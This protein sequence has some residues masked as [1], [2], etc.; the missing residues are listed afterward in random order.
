MATSTEYFYNLTPDRIHQAFAQAGLELTPT[1]RWLNSMENRVVG[2]EDLE[3]ERW[4]GKFY[5]PGRWSRAALEE[6]HDFMDEL[7]E[8]DLPVRP[9]VELENGATVG[10]VEGIFFTIFPHHLG[11]MPDEV[12]FEHA[13]LLGGLV[14]R[15]HQVGARGRHRRRPSVGPADWGLKSLQELAREKVV[16]GPIWQRYQERVQTL[17]SRLKDRFN[18]H[19]QLR[20]HGDLHRGNILWSS[21]GPSFVDFDDTTTGP[22]VQDLWMLLPGRDNDALA[23]RE[24][25]LDSYQRHRAFDRKELEL[26][27]P[28]RAL[29]FVRHAAWVAKR[30]KD[31]AFFRLYPDVESH[32]FWRRELDD[33]E[34]QLELVR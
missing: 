31:P 8:A 12:D 11:R 28:L 9:P 21:L 13:D 26:I 18:R 29:K 17:C 15:L 3:G 27:E 5:R 10:Q 33:L 20:L 16:P 2:V 32:G 24:V 1:L 19:Q 4:V 22:A 7:F 34:G 25:F 23:L 30:R 14:A 6:E